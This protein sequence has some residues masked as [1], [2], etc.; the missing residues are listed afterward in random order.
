MRWIVDWEKYS[1][2]FERKSISSNSGCLWQIFFLKISR[3]KCWATYCVLGYR[4]HAL[5]AISS[6]LECNTDVCKICGL[7]SKPSKPFFKKHWIQLVT[8]LQETPR[9]AAIVVRSKCSEASK[10]ASSRFRWLE[11]AVV[12]RSS[13]AVRVWASSSSCGSFLGI[14][15]P[16]YSKIAF[17]TE[18]NKCFWADSEGDGGSFEKIK[19][20]DHKTKKTTKKIK[21][22]H[23]MIFTIY[24][25]YI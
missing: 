16:L 7:D 3:D 10:I 6:N 17:M 18:E 21:S 19:I 9:R 22:P 14:S 23:S 11:D 25:I 12:R 2:K 13:N 1:G 4:L 5:K 24:L 20:Y 8:E 15:I